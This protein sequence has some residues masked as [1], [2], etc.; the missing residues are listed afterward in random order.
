MNWLDNLINNLDNK[1]KDNYPT[2]CIVDGEDERVIES[3]NYVKYMNVV[4]LGNKEVITNKL[5]KVNNNF[6][7]VEV[8]TPTI[9]EEL[10]NIIVDKTKNSKKPIAKDSAK[11]LIKT[12]PWY[13]IL[14]LESGKVDCVVGGATYPTSAIL[15]PV[16]K[17]IKTKEQGGLISSYMIMSKEEET[18]IFSD[19]A[20]NI[21]PDSSQLFNIT[22]D[23]IT[24]VKELGLKPTTALLS[25]STLGS[26]SG[27]SVDKVKEVYNNY[28][29]MYPEEKENIIGEIQFDTAIDENVRRIKLKDQQ[30]SG[31]INTFIFPD[32]NSGNIGY[33]IAQYLGGYEAIGPILQG[34]R[35]PVNDLSRGCSAKEISKVIY[36]TVAQI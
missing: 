32:L 7:N 26:G 18:L 11:E 23:T 27:E 35:K 16:L 25:Y 24:S 33:K 19:C 5:T 1:N 6:I 30:V 12:A 36:L 14:L 15:T 8:L 28:I 4:L 21:N 3:L 13:A 29:N 10:V 34:C 22:K 31:K 9:D 2:V 20:L 17:I